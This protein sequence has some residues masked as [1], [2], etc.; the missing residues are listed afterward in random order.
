MAKGSDAKNFITKEE[1]TSFCLNNKDM[2]IIFLSFVFKKM[3]K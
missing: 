3:K 1:F 2:L